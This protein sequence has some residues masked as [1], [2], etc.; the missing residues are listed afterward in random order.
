MEWAPIT[1]D[2]RGEWLQIELGAW[3]HLEGYSISAAYPDYSI[4]AEDGRL[5]GKWGEEWSELHR[6]T[7]DRWGSS[8]NVEYK[9]VATPTLV[10]W[11]D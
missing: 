8:D 1:N 2:Y 4:G 3:L 7:G 5:Y 10:D 9:A 11:Q 6:Y